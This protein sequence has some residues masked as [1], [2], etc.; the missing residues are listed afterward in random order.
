MSLTAPTGDSRQ[1]G[2]W[3]QC[4][5]YVAII[6]ACLPVLR[7]VIITLGH[8]YLGWSMAGSAIGGSDKSRGHSGSGGPSTGA[9]ASTSRRP[10][11]SQ[12]RRSRAL[13]AA[14]APRGD[15]IRLDDLESGPTACDSGPG[16]KSAAGKAAGRS[17]IVVTRRVSIQSDR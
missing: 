1:A 12:S 13:S 11:M 7:V 9:S 16:E 14:D 8:R 6:C 4:E 3:S 2:S 5:L 15:F 17:T 10:R